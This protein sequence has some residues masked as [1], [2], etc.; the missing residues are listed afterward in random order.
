MSENP[1]SVMEKRAAQYDHPQRLAAAG[2]YSYYRAVEASAGTQ[3]V[4]DG[5]QVNM[6]GSNDYLGLADHPLVKEAAKSAI[7]RYGTGPSG[8]R[9]LN[10]SNDLHERLEEAVAAF[11]GKPHAIVFPSGYQANVGA[12]SALVGRHDVLL[13][14]AHNHASL[15]DGA[16]LS[17]GKS[18]KFDHNDPAD[19][20]RALE[21]TRP[22]APDALQLVAV[23]S[24][25]S[26]AG[27]TSP[28]SE[29]LTTCRAG[30]AALMVDEA[31][32]LGVI[33]PG[34]RGGAAA[35]G[36]TND[37]AFVMGTF[38]KALASV[39]GFI[40][41]DASLINF[42]KHRSRAL[43]FSAALSP[44]SAASALAAL[45]LLRAEPERVTRLQH[46]SRF[47]REHLRQHG[48]LVATGPELSTIPIIPIH[49]GSEEAAF[50]LAARA[51][52]A[53]VFV[54]P[55]IPPAVPVGQALIRFCL[56][57]THTEAQIEQAVCALAKCREAM[58]SSS[59]ALSFEHAN[60]A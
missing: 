2:V 4:I 31:H 15:L 37:V 17:F 16:R 9:I 33:G 55:V 40:A 54:N 53:G 60:A 47:A 58:N 41:A 35:H 56:M 28:L 45:E 32:G 44:A 23:E 10:G 38:S 30:N 11:V 7:D 8:S 43:V 14:D 3:V 26:M 24:V 49:A 21:N 1:K 48:F 39:G 25:Y 18:F 19:L 57:A 50:S 22:T 29:I 20:A 5:R 36:I 27:D 42:L 46:N 59:P 13:Q 52:H 6:F 12:L 51:F 34:G